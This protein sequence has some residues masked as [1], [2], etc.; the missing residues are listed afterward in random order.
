MQSSEF[1]SVLSASIANQMQGAYQALKTAGGFDLNVLI[2][3]DQLGRADGKNVRFGYINGADAATRLA[4]A[5]ALA[6]R[7][8]A[9]LVVYGYLTEETDP[10]SLILEFYYDTQAHAGE[11]DALWGGYELGAPLSADVSYAANPGLAKQRMAERLAPRIRALFGMTQGL[12]RILANQPQRALTILRETERAL[13]DEWLAADGK[14]VLY[15]FLGAAALRGGEL[16]AAIADL[17]H[18]LALQPDY[19]PALHTMG[20]VYLQRAQLSLLRNRELSAEELQCVSAEGVEAADATPAAALAS[21]RRAIQYLEDA[22]RSARQWHWPPYEYRVRMDLGGAYRLLGDWE[23]MAMNFE[24]ASLAFANAERE[25]Q[26][27]LAGFPPGEEAVYYGWTQVNLGAVDHLRAR[28]SRRERDN[29]VVAGNISLASAKQTEVAGWLREAVQH[30][31]AC[32][33]LREQT[34]GNPYFQQCVYQ[35]SCVK[36][37][38][39]AAQELSE[40]QESTP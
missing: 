16:D 9:D 29:A 17:E 4:A 26:A 2:W 3:D 7:V 10:A 1:G 6:Y 12:A 11:P 23:R 38:N 24:A 30:Y 27:A 18:A 34:A 40:L 37:Q 32:L 21:T 20:S 19:A 15:L 31:Q 22:A 36:S 33:D 13:Q 28:L 39:L 25:L 5:K 35:F 8:K 14:E